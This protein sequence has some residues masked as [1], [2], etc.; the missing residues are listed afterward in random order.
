[1]RDAYAHLNANGVE[2]LRATNHINQ[3]SFYFADPDGNT[4]K[5]YYELPTP[6]SCSPRAGGRSG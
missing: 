2:V 1:L 3:R 5:I 4:L 6:W